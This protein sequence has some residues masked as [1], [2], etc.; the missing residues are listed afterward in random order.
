MEPTS[1]HT[2][3]GQR[4]GRFAI[5]ALAVAAI[6]LGIVIAA[7]GVP[8]APAHPRLVITAAEIAA[9]RQR[10]A[11]NSTPEAPAWR[12]FRD[13][14]AAEALAASPNVF[15]GPFRGPDLEMARDALQPLGTDGSY[16]RDLGIAYALSGDRQYARKAR[17]FLLAWAAGNTPTTIDD[18]DSKDTGQLQSYGAFSFAYAYDLTYES[19]VYSGDDGSLIKSWFRRF[20][21]ALQSCNRPTLQDYFLEHPDDYSGVY[22]WDPSKHYSQYDSYIGGDFPLLIQTASL[23]MAHMSGYDEVERRILDDP[24]N[25]LRAEN[26]VARSLSPRNDGDGAGTRPVPQKTIYKI[27]HE[28]R[29]GMFDYMTYNTRVAAVLVDMAQRIGWDKG[30]TGTAR[31]RLYASWSYLARFF[32]PGAEP[33]F[34]PLDVVHTD[35]CLPRFTLAWRAF[36]DRR[37]A[38][39]LDSG[40]RETYYEPQLLGPVTVTHSTLR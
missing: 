10:I 16:A 25:V 6:G 37:F 2:S 7:C 20:T 26:I 3:L 32:G 13:T 34:N 21:D 33:N 40:P 19:G 38:T 36:G 12:V 27:Y 1:R 15:P 8:D 14:H 22:E 18:W 35:A 4:R 30:K 28:G 39:V 23:A 24:A 11:D 31:R 17:G 5:A 9:I 29:G